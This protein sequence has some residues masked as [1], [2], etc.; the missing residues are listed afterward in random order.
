VLS[1]R[2]TST[3]ETALHVDAMLSQTAN[4]TERVAIGRAV[5]D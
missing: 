3:P 4:A 2:V 5:P 1:A